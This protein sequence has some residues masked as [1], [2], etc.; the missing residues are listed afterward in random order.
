MKKTLA[1]LLALVL[2]VALLAGCGAKTQPAAQPE[3]QKYV[4]KMHL[5]VGD[6]DPS[7]DAA[8]KF[9]SIVE[10]G[11]DGNIEI[12][13]YPSSSLGTTADCLDGLSLGACDIVYDCFANLTPVTDL[14]NIDP[15][16]YMYSGLEHYKAVW[17]GELGAEI[18]AKVGEESGMQVMN[19]GLM[20]IRVLTS[21]KP[22]YGPEDAKG[23]KIRV[24][25][26]PIYIDTWDWL[27]A[28]PTPLPG[29]EIF[30]AL[31]QGTVDAQENPYTSSAGNSFHEVVDYVTETNHVYSTLVYVMDQNFFNAMPV[32]YQ[33]LIKR[34]AAEAAPYCTEANQALTEEKKQLFIDVGCEIIET[35]V[36]AWQAA[37]D[38]FIEEK[39]PYLLE[40]YNKIL[41]ADPS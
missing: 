6:T 7:A 8:R 20:G 29:G 16:P 41:E 21:N 14:G 40:Y 25:T 5:A 12:Q 10:E 36:S 4:L 34:A 32:E 30:T 1:L 31:Q 18:L 15:I 38:G 13:M 33:E 39:Y 9:K 11:S 27:G 37:L 24:P 28:N 35:D 22:V 2:A 23:L 3:A 19:G 17:E 26:T